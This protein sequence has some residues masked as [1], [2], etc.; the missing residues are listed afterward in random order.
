MTQDQVISILNGALMTA[1]TV[2]APILIVSIVVGLV[3]SIIQA[4]TQV[5][6]QTITFVPK[7]IAIALIL[8]ALGPW[9]MS[10][11]VD[12]M[13]RIMLDVLTYLK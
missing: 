12:Y 1:I 6:E 10:K 2:A 7:I 8:I 13:N 3:I 9:M 4:A 5:N 11:M